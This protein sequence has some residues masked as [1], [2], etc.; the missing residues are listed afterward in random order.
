MPVRREEI[1]CPPLSVSASVPE[2]RDLQLPFSAR[3]AASKL[4]EIFLSLSPKRWYYSCGL[5]CLPFHLGTAS[6]LIH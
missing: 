6:A 3:L 4:Q 5:P 2:T 1:R